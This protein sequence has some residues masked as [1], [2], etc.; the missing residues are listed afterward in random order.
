MSNL[1]FEKTFLFAK[2]IAYAMGDKYLL[3]LTTK[4]MIFL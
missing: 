2:I 4:R 3:L 1:T